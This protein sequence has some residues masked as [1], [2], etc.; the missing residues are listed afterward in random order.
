[1][2]YIAFDC[3]TRYT[4]AVVEGQQRGLCLVEQ[5]TG[6]DL[7]RVLVARTGVTLEAPSRPPGELEL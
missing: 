5:R 4:W 3:R 2:K 7:G 6:G 1:M